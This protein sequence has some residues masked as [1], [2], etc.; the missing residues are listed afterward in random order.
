MTAAYIKKVLDAHGLEYRTDGNRVIGIE[1]FTI[2][3]E[4]P[5]I[6]IATAA[7]KYITETREEIEEIDYT[8]WTKE[9]LLT[10]LGY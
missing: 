1:R 5:V 8:G 2:K 4:Y 6:N 7:I 3:T 10:W 9:E